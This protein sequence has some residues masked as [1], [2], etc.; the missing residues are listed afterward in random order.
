MTDQAALDALLDLAGVSCSCWP[1][2][3][4]DFV[5]GASTRIAGPRGC[6]LSGCDVFEAWDAL[7]PDLQ[8]EVSRLARTVKDD[9]TILERIQVDGDRLVIL[10]VAG[11]DRRADGS[12]ADWRIQSPVRIL[13]EERIPPQDELRAALDDLKGE[14]VALVTPLVLKLQG[15]IDRRPRLKKILTWSPRPAF[16]WGHWAA[17]GLVVRAYRLAYRIEWDGAAYGITDVLDGM[18]QDSRSETWTNAPT[19]RE[20]ALEHEASEAEA[21]WER[22]QEDGRP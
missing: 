16:G 20:W 8:A 5:S 17:H 15:A 4:P 2:S 21:Y 10:D 7:G 6:H 18:D 22:L 9:P 1:P 3:A 13:A 11:H 14:I 12:T 19:F